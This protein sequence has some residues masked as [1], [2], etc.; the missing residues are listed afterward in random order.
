[1]LIRLISRSG[2]IS[3]RRR[4]STGGISARRGSLLNNLHKNKKIKLENQRGPI[5]GT[6]R[7]Q[8]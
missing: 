8:R 7:T 2:R 1:L 3:T 5:K 4:V 6:E